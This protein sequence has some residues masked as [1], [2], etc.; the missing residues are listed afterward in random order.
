MKSRLYNFGDSWAWGYNDNFET[1][2]K[3]TY[4][5]IIAKNFGL[6]KVNACLSG[7]GMG[8]VGECFLNHYPDM[9]SND[10]VLV[11][12]PPDTRIAVAMVEG[13]STRTVF[14]Q[15]KFWETLVEEIGGN[16]YHF[17]LGIIKECMMI[18][19]LCKAKNIKYAFQHNYATMYFSDEWDLS[20]IKDNFC[21]PDRSMMDLLGIDNDWYAGSSLE[22][23]VQWDMDGP[24]FDDRDKMIPPGQH[25]RKDRLLNRSTHPTPEGAK[26][27]ADKLTHRLREIWDMQPTSGINSVN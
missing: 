27:I 23:Q 5:G 3:T 26:I 11:T 2:Y 16:P 10:C 8:N 13:R 7:W 19:G 18:A 20:I 1:P 12:I 15:D 9:N 24:S 25:E 4:A 14:C 6:K 17:E 22:E 21:Y